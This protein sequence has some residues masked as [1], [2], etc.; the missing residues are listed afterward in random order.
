M[1]GPARGR[2]GAGA[3][4]DPAA[5]L[6]VNAGGHGFYRVAH[7][8]ELRGRMSGEVLG[9]LDTLE[10]YNLVDDAWNEVVA[11]RLPAVDF[12]AFVEGFGGERELAVWQSIVDRPSRA[13]SPARRR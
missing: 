7:S 4:R 11:G 5:P 2:R 9:S 8:D 12:L 13:R 1:V 3:A 6:V 10:R